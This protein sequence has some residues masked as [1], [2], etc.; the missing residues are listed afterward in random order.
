MSTLS[1]P[2]NLIQ[3][4]ENDT[5]V[6]W[7]IKDR[8]S[9]FVY[10]NKA[11]KVWQTIS[12]TYD[13]EGLKIHDV[14]VPVAEF[15]DIFEQQ[16][17][18]VE[19]SGTVLR[20]ITT[21]IQGREKIMQPV[22]NIQEPLYDENGLCIGTVISVRHVNILTPTS[23]LNGKLNQHATF[24]T[25][26]ELFTEKEWEVMYLL[27]CNLSLKEIS[28]VLGISVDAVNGR[29]RSSFKKTEVNSSTALV[30]FCRTNRFDN[31][32][33]QFFLKKGHIVI[34]G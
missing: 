13:Y 8:T 4:F 28:N 33:P 15:A 16:E 34:T 14:P 2:K 24:Q 10:V 20:A 3:M 27:L 9:K 7:A 32:I 21:H 18:F 26:S 22:Y 19:S 5:V 30:D 12:T 11:F 29:L 6:G 25:P 1:I 17:R 31:Y 23:L